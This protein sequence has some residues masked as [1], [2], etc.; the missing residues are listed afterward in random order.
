MTLL[1]P[2]IFLNAL[3]TTTMGPEKN[4]IATMIQEQLPNDPYFGPILQDVTNNPEPD[5]TYTISEN[6]LLHKG[7]ICIPDSNDI[8]RVILQEC[9]IAPAAGHFGIAK[10]MIWSLVITIG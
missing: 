1:N 3:T 7:A 9:H 5:S 2:K 4:E 6:L 8:K 10:F